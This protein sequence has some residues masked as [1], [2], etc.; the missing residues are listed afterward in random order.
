MRERKVLQEKE[1]AEREKSICCSQALKKRLAD[2]C[3]M[4]Q[5]KE[6]FLSENTKDLDRE[7]IC[8]IYPGNIWVGI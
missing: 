8:N 7:Q 6:I 5:K 2:T 4:M 3:G 1:S